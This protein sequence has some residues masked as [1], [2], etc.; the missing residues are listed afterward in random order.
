MLQSVGW[1]RVRYHWMTKHC[2]SRSQRNF[3]RI[4][5]SYVQRDGERGFFKSSIIYNA[6]TSLLDVF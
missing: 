4:T 1:Q 3:G 6:F 5:D 2:V